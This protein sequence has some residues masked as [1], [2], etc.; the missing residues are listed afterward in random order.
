MLLQTN[1]DRYYG[2]VVARFEDEYGHELESLHMCDSLV[3]V[4]TDGERIVMKQDWRGQECYFSQHTATH[5]EQ[6]G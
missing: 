4:F 6:A 2:K 3:I 5:L 1:A